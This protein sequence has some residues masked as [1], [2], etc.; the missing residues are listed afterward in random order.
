M[1]KRLLIYLMVL[2]MISMTAACGMGAEQGEDSGAEEVTTGAED[3]GEEVE[4]ETEEEVEDEIKDGEEDEMSGEIKPSIAK[5]ENGQFVYTVRNETEN[6][7]TFEFSSSQRYDYAVKDASGATVFLYSSAAAFMQVLGTE[8]LAPGEELSY[9]IE[10]PPGEEVKGGGV[11][12]V[13][14]TPR[15]GKKAQISTKLN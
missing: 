3:E 14:L 10:L 8:T 11:L 5:N 1:I 12:E 13:W 7:V 6:E 4:E 15:G 2:F 9:T